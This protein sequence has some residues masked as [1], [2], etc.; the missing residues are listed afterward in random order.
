MPVLRTNALGADGDQ[1]LFADLF[2]LQASQVIFSGF[3]DFGS[4][5]RLCPTPSGYA[6]EAGDKQLAQRID[7]LETKYDGQFQIVFLATG[8]LEILCTTPLAGVRFLYV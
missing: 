6:K 2:K 1:R 5:L 7:E 8:R 3:A 4:P